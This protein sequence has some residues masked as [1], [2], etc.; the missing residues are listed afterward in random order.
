MNTPANHFRPQTTQQRRAVLQQIDAIES[1]TLPPGFDAE[2]LEMDGLHFQSHATPLAHEP[3]SI[4]RLSEQVRQA[5]AMNT[6]RRRQALAQLP[7]AP[8]SQQHI[9]VVKSHQARRAAAEISAIQ[10]HYANQQQAPR[11]DQ[12]PQPPMAQ[13][14]L[15]ERIRQN[16]AAANTSDRKATWFV[17]GVMLFCLAANFAIPYFT[18]SA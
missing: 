12:F 14:H 3:D 8:L 11:W 9:A 6:R 15:G 17:A 10:T 13:D 4:K 18:R 2:M 5:D 16:I 7:L 1:Q